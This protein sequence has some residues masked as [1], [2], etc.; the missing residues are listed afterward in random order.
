MGDIMATNHDII[1]VEYE[2]ESKSLQLTKEDCPRLDVD[3]ISLLR[4]VR[5]VINDANKL[6]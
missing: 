3:G 1:T 4:D 5:C 2:F 6:V